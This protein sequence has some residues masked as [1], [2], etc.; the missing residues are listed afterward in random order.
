MELWEA[1]KGRRSIGKV[2]LDV[3]PRECI[4]KILEAATWAPSHHQTQPWKFFVLQGRARQRLG[5]EMARI[6]MGKIADQE[7]EDVRAKIEKLK[8]KPLR[9][10]VVIAVAVTPSEQEKV[11]EIEEIEAVAC[12]VQNMMLAAHELGLGTIWRTGS[13]TYEPDLKPFFGLG[14]RDRL[15]GFVYVG[16]PDL[17]QRESVGRP[18]TEKTVWYDE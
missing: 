10:P 18:F 1:L 7:T 2:K 9:A 17:P 4:E 5:E 8:S 6:A 15:L 14:E 13:I 11:V 16:Y 12:A 3:P